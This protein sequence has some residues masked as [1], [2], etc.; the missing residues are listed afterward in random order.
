M[1]GRHKLLLNGRVAAQATIQAAA[2]GREALLGYGIDGQDPLRLTC[3]Q[4][5]RKLA[6]GVMRDGVV[7]WGIAFSATALVAQVLAWAVLAYVAS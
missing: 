7:A 2:P 5:L 1:H 4:R 3:E 6:A